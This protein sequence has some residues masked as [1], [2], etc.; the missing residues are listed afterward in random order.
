MSTKLTH[1]MSIGYIY[2]YIYA[3][4]KGLIT[5]FGDETMFVIGKDGYTNMYATGVCFLSGQCSYVQLV[6]ENKG[7]TVTIVITF[8]SLHYESNTDKHDVSSPSLLLT[9]SRSRSYW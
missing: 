4:H 3:C 1:V 9:H 2:I 7:T 5:D 8:S 6:N